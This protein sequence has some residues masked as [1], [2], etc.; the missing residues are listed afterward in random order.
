MS[1]VA[2]LM[3]TSRWRSVAIRRPSC[4]ASFDSVFNLESL[5]HALELGPYFAHVKMLLRS[6]G[7]YGCM[8]CYPTL[9]RSPLV[10]PPIRT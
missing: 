1:A 5:C 2:T 3:P 4:T 6:G 10:L 9:P 8:D 7:T